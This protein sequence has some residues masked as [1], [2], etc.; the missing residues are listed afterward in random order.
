VLALQLGAALGHYGRVEGD[1]GVE[2]AAVDGLERT[3]KD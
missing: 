3:L 2:R 1:E